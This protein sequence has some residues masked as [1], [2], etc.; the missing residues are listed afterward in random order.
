M[1]HVAAS[2]EYLH[3]VLYPTLTLCPLPYPSKFKG[4]KGS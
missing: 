3:G 4:G 1:W 2:R